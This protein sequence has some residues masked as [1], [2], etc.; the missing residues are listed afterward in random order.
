MNEIKHD[1]HPHNEIKHIN[2]KKKTSYNDAHN[3]IKHI[4]EKH[5][6]MTHTMR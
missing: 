3:E 1:A 2:E 4:N 5:H 6:I